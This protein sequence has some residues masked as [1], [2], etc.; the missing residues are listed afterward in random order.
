MKQKTEKQKLAET[1]KAHITMWRKKD[2]IVVEEE[3]E[4]LDDED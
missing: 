2:W 1:N 4:K 3:E